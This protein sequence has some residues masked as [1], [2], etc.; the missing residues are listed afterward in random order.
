MNHLRVVSQT[1]GDAV[2]DISVGDHAYRIILDYRVA[3]GDI[4]TSSP[5]IQNVP[6][7]AV[8]DVIDDVEIQPT[9]ATASTAPLD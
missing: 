5:N 7:E 6:Q 3:V 9:H 2:A 4:D 1:T 8:K